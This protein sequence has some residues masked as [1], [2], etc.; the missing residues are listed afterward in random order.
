M[1]LAG[2]QAVTLGGY[3][4]VELV[5]FIVS[6]GLGL[7]LLF[8]A[9]GEARRSWPGVWLALYFA[10]AAVLFYAGS[11]RY[12]LPLAPAVALLLVGVVRSRIALAAM[13]AVH[14][15]LGLSL[16]E[17]ERRHAEGYRNFAAALEPLAGPARIWSN[18]EWGLRHYLGRL[19]GEP[20]LRDQSV[21]A[22]AIVVESDLAA[23]VS[24]GAAGSRREL[25][26]AEI[27]PGPLGVRTIGR[28]SHSGYS[29]SDFGVLPFGWRGGPVDTVTAWLVGRPEPTLSH[30][31]LADPAAEA[32]LLAGFFP[33]DGAAW[34]W[35][36]PRGAAVLL[37]PPGATRFEL[38]FHIPEQ[39]PARRV[40]IE[41]DGRI[42]A[43][44]SY[45]TTG[46]YVLQAPIERAEGP[47]RVV[48][49]ATPSYSP[50]GDGRE[51]AI[52]VNALG[53]Q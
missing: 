14:L 26:R 9:V 49:R 43:A 16:A 19:G 20:L 48:I 5:F 28:G 3:S 10:A 29:S 25:L 6:A 45:S 32:H 53:F 21:P 27:G 22:G 46:G 44:E 47:A 37:A 8:A 31:R 33:S 40:E 34:R 18:A 50:P 36:G 2:A 15:A 39:A 24:Y 38:D 35:M 23:T 1:L 4:T 12:L 51:L 42:V 11:A 52:V 7:A 30:L 17:A 41:I 13:L